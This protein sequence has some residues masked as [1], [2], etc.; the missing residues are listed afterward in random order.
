MGVVTLVGIAVATIAALWW[1]YLKTRHDTGSSWAGRY[2]QDRSEDFALRH[3][4][5]WQDE[6]RRQRE[7]SRAVSAEK[8]RTDRE[9]Q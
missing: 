8:P 1:E 4:P 6:R 3:S 9:A 2:S 7:A 5:S